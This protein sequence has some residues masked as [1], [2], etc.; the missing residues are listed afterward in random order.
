VSD[1]ILFLK[2]LGMVAETFRNGQVTV[3][4]KGTPELLAAVEQGH[5]AVSVAAKAPTL[6]EVGLLLQGY[7]GLAAL[8]TLSRADKSVSGGLVF[9]CRTECGSFLPSKLKSGNQ[10]S[11]MDA[12]AQ[13]LL[14]TGRRHPFSAR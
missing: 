6:P 5:L 10:S 3:R 13:E 4:K 11:S 12:A 7:P 2:R 14:V 9:P 8:R 1:V